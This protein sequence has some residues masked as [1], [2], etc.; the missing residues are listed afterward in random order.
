MNLTLRQVGSVS[1]EDAIE[2]L[3]EE[4]APEKLKISTTSS[5]AP[6]VLNDE[7]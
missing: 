5:T 4:L 1:C 6:P 2:R 3:E 7:E